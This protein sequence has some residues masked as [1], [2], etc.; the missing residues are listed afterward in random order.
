[1]GKQ[2]AGKGIVEMKGCF[3]LFF[4]NE[5][6]ADVAINI[7]IFVIYFYDG[8]NLVTFLWASIPSIHPYIH[9][10]IHPLTITL[11]RGW[12]WEAGTGCSLDT[13]P[14][15]NRTELNIETIIQPHIH[16]CG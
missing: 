11:I 9:P 7:T 15:Y 13:S 8:K 4:S 14:V 3:V 1:M 5:I 12:S 16:S 6:K 10:S 2:N